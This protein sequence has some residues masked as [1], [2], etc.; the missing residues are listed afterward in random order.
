ME[1]GINVIVC[2]W[3][4][5][6]GKG[7]LLLTQILNVCLS[8]FT[9][10]HECETQEDDCHEHADCMNEIGSYDCKCH[11]GYVGDGVSCEGKINLILDV[12][13]FW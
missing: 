7:G 5:I 6:E 2:T 9:D 3:A 4:Y 10:V 8:T 13:Y 12:Y 1:T 11:L